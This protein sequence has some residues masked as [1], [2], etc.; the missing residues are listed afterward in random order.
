MAPVDEVHQQ[1][2]QQR[3][4]APAGRA[5]ATEPGA[6]PVPGPVTGPDPAAASAPEPGPGPGG[7]AGLVRSSGAMAAGT[8]VSRA[9]GFLRNVVI[10]AA[11]GSATVGDAF[12]LANAVPN[13]LFTLI[14]GGLLNAVFVPQLVRAMTAGEEEGRAYA[15]RLLTLAVL[16]LAGVTLVAT[17]AAPLVVRLYAGGE[18]SPA[19]L[20]L[21]TAF[22]YWCLPQ[23]FFYGL[24][25]LL[26]QVLNARGSFGPMMWTPIL[27]NLVAIATGLLFIAVATVGPRDSGSLDGGEIALLGAGTT[28]GIV[29]QALALVPVLRRVG[30]RYRPRLDL[31]GSGLGRAGS[32]AKWTLAYVGVTQLAYLVVVRL[33]TDA[34][35]LVAE[36][37][38]PGSGYL[39]YQNAYLMLLLPHSI[40]TVSVVTALLPRM[41]RQAVQGDLR[42]VRDDLSHGLRLVGVV[43][44]PASV[45]FLLLGPELGAALFSFGEAS[46]E[47]G[48][49]IGRVLS[50]FALGLVPFSAHYL[51]L[52]GF[53]ALEDT[54]T[55][56]LLA[57][58]IAALDVGAAL[59]AYSVLPAEHKTVGV[60][61]AYAL[62][63]VVGFVVS[64]L[65]LRRRV[66]GL[67]G[68]RVLRTYVR[69][70]VAALVAGLLAWAVLEAVRALMPEGSYA[71]V[72]LG[73]ALSLPLAAVTYV[74]A[75]RR[76][77]VR[78]VTRL[79]G[80]LRA[81]LGR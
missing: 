35:K 81:R 43:L 4:G 72:V 3:A 52:R 46:V 58:L 59:V 63:Y 47:D 32:L 53:Y 1:D 71:G 70:A 12:A 5:T 50:A 6:G 48:L 51:V 75:A 2:A 77:R 29:V 64:A 8:V 22:A 37:G 57:A 17:L 24:Y 62:A 45:L 13:V 42:S 78:E 73:L 41:S 20:R 7:P 33:T 74:L 21:S 25:T 38:G 80:Q 14:A 16:V 39:A 15:D 44:V 30:Y 27:N 54:R 28:L 9:L 67:D 10:V 65:T 18:L 49:A 66:G 61:A 26:G 23:I 40:I 11:L 34:G 19:D 76:M 69:L 79:T 31:R 55:P 56:F 68:H 36:Q 60:A